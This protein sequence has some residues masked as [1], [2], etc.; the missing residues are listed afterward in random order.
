V[1]STADTFS[2]PRPIESAAL[3]LR[4]V[5]ELAVLVEVGLGG[6]LA[7]AAVQRPSLLTSMHNGRFTGWFAGPLHGLLPSLT[8]D[9]AD[10]KTD[11]HV[12]LIGMGVAWLIVVL[13]GALVRD[14]VVIAAVVALNGIFLLCPPT[15]LTDLFNY[16]GYA[17]LEAVQDLNPYVQLPLAGAHGAVY[18]FSNWHGLRSPYGPLFTVIMLPLSRLP[19]PAAYWA[20]KALVTAASLGML[21]AVWGCARRLERPPAAAVA[22]VGLNPLVL[23]YALGGKHLEV[24]MMAC[25]MAGALLILSRR[26]V[27]GGAAL[28]A[29]VAIQ[30]SAA[31]LAPVIALG[32]ARRGRALAGL[33]AGGLVLGAV[34]LLAFGPHLPSVGDQSRLV[35]SYSFPNLIGYAAGHGGA[36]ATVRRAFAIAALAGGGVCAAVALWRRRWATAAGFAALIAIFCVP[37]LMPWYLLWA[38]PFAALSDSRALRTATVAFG[39]WLLLTWT[40]VV[41]TYL[42]THGYHPRQT[43]TGRE[44]RAFERTLLAPCSAHLVRAPKLRRSHGLAARRP[45]REAR[46]AARLCARRGGGADRAAAVARG[47]KR[48]VEHHRTRRRAHRHRRRARRTL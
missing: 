29:A 45:A 3:T 33:A 35:G 31:L 14:G 44:N 19:L 8:R 10:L 5:G 26:E 38:L 1:T 15:A 16:I 9:P 12:A 22:F 20:Y 40:A 21:A 42:S 25:V 30:A 36:D 48:P 17:R 27:A 11:L 39:V 2:L 4:R 32:T 28:A 37:W 34:S 23:F 46:L 18:A 6:A 47:R 41:P 7:L 24:L 13:T 43:L